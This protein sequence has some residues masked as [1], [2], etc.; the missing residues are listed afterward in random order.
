MQKIGEASIAVYG[1]IHGNVSLR[2]LSIFD[3]NK[4]KWTEVFPLN[5][6]LISISQPKMYFEMSSILL[7]GI[8]SEKNLFKK[9][10]FELKFPE[11]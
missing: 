6:S 8:I 3:L 1:G 9:A 7:M 5:N 10:L 4:Q 11:F 2:D